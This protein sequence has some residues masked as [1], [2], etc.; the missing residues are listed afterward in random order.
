MH[1]NKVPY[2]GFSIAV[3]TLYPVKNKILEKKKLNSICN[4]LLCFLYDMIEN[5]LF[6]LKEYNRVICAN[7]TK[8]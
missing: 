5:K 6:S 7:V 8:L 4:C 2:F 3:N 1:K